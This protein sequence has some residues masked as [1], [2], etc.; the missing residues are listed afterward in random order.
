MSAVRQIARGTFFR[1]GQSMGGFVLIHPQVR[2]GE[3]RLVG[4][5]VVREHGKA[6]AGDEEELLAGSDLDVKLADA[7]LQFEFL[8]FRRL[9]RATGDHRD[10]LVAGVPH[11]HVVRPQH[12]AHPHRLA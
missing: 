1:P 12:P 5:G 7:L 8:A 11:D 9:A 6:R 10:E 4:D 3:Q 2:V